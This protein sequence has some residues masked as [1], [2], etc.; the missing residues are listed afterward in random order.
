MSRPIEAA[1][2]PLPRDDT[3]PPVMKMYFV[4]TL[5]PSSCSGA[6]AKRDLDSGHVL[7]RVDPEIPPAGGEDANRA[8]PLE[9]AELLQSFHP[10]QRRRWP[11]GE[12]QKKVPAINVDA[13]VLPPRGAGP[14][15]LRVPRMGDARAGEIECAI[16]RV[17]HHLDDV[18]V[19]RLAGVGER[20]RQSP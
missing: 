14:V 8:S 12:L 15:R 2:R 6:F 1:A 19:L 17:A 10:L 20:H 5:T 13:D 9:R 3:T 18:G 4:A 11:G 7:R 16:R